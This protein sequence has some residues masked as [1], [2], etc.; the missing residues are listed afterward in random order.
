[1]IKI[2]IEGGEY[3]LANELL[4]ALECNKSAINCV[5]MEFHDTHSR[6]AEF[7]KLV[8]GVSRH[9]PIVHLHGNNC[10]PVASDGLPHVI[11]ITFAQN[12]GLTT[13]QQLKFPLIGLDYPNDYS[14]PDCVFEFIPES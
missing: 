1:M 10:A 5:V 13:S 3:Q 11:E 4:N 12:T 7:Q 6:R 2:D 8:E 14:V 9:L